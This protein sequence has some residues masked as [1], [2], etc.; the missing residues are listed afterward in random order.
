MR[1][2]SQIIGV[3]V[4]QEKY[5]KGITCQTSYNSWKVEKLKSFG[6]L[7]MFFLSCAAKAFGV[8]DFL[9]PNNIDEPIPQ[10]FYFS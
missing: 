8:T 6:R 5:V 3:D 1:G 7:L 10:V 9:N 2:A 4:M